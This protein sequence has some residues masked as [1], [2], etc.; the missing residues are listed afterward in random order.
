MG[1]SLHRTTPTL[2]LAAAFLAASAPALASEGPLVA[3]PAG[4]FEGTQDDTVSVFRGIAYAEAPSGEL[5]WRP[6]VRKADAAEPVDA[7]RFGDICHQPE[8]PDVPAN[9]YYED[10]PP[11][12][13]D[14]LLLNIWRPAG[15]EKVPVLVWIHGGSLLTG[16]SRFSLYDGKRMAER[17][18]MVVSINYRLGALGFLAHPALSAESPEG[19]SGNYGLLDQIEAL[20]WVERNIAAFGGDPD[21]VTVAGESAG[22]LSVMHLM[23]SPLA[24]GLFDKA[25]MQ[26]AYM[27]SEPALAEDRNGHPSAE[28]EGL[29]VAAAAGTDT[30]ADMRSMDA[31][32]LTAKA[33]AAGF[34]TYPTVDGKVVPAQLVEVF[35]QGA[36]AQVPIIAGFNS[37]EIRSLRV[38]L[39][40]AP[41]GSRE[42]E[43]KIRA[44]YG[45]VADVFLRIYPSDAIDQSMLETTRDALYGWTSQ[46]LAEKQPAE[47][48][49]Y[50]YVFDRPYPAADKA[51]LHAFHGSELPYMFGTIDQT[52]RNWPRI[53]RTREERGFSDAMVD[54]WT[55]F[56]RTGIP[57][58]AD[59]PEW[60]AYE[61]GQSWMVFGEDRKVVEDVLS[62]RYDL[63]EHV[64]CR[65]RAAGNQQW[66]WN[67]G[68]GA[69][70]LPPLEGD[71]G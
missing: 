2:A 59:G 13:E 20:R 35:D 50:L 71:C 16:A 30:L 65:R 39:P 45:D 58:A 23:A 36:Q 6:P 57:E 62:Y 64:V 66:N 40:P 43:E 55:S 27:V 18:V 32:E 9:I 68:V 7:T 15:A 24:H 26:S 63:I 42:Y 22:G 49:A 28:S 61:Q 69:P 12:S 1:R 21:N 70:V 47:T 53:P 3:A 25:I 34:R 48:Q 54:Y 44:A 60:P 51:G 17:G 29:R 38:L 31:R 33:T 37:G 4:T 46:R 5:R 52:A 67:V 10:L 41:S 56:A 11:R 8:L 14:C 19:I